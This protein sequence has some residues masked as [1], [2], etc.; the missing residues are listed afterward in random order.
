MLLCRLHLIITQNNLDYDMKFISWN[1]NGLRAV[2]Q[3]GFED[4]FKNIDADFFC[5]QETKMQAGQ[6]DASLT[7]TNPIGTMQTRRVT[8]EQLSLPSTSP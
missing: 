1:V 4:I 8:Q 3:K 7:A 5:L 2:Y 6:L